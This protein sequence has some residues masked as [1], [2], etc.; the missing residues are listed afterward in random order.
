[1]ARFRRLV[2]GRCAGCDV[3]A[4]LVRRRWPT[5]FIELPRMDSKSTVWALHGRLVPDGDHSRIDI[6][7]LPFV[8]GRRGDLNLT[9]RSSAISSVHAQIDERDGTLWIRDLN[10]K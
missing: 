7:M 8:I 1:M 2:S 6:D 9:L 4:P 3:G 5:L 10:S